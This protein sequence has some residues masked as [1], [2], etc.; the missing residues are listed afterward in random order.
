MYKKKYIL[1]KS[2]T[3]SSWYNNKKVMTKLKVEH[4]NKYAKY[5]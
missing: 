3:K 2:T 4:Y 1:P 5:E